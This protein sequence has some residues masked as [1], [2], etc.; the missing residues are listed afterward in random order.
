MDPASFA[1]SV[2]AVFKDAYLTAKFIRKTVNSIKGHR[3]EQ[4]KAV[5]RLTVQIYRLKN[6]SRLF[7]GVDGNKVDMQLLETV[8]N[9][10]LQTVHE[11]LEQ[12]QKVLADYTKLAA[13]LDEDY[14]TYSP[15]SPSFKFDP[16]KDTLLIDD[17]DD[18]LEGSCEPGGEKGDQVENSLD[19]K[20]KGWSFFGF[21][22]KNPSVKNIALWS[23]GLDPF[24]SLPPGVKWLFVK[25]KLEVTLRQFEDWNKQLEYLVGPL[26]DGFGFFKNPSLLSRLRP[27]GDPKLNIN[28]DIFQGHIELNS[29]SAE[30]Q[31]GAKDVQVADGMIPPSMSCIR[32]VADR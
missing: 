16:V 15:L 3:G 1:F 2:V 14:Q 20:G 19:V 6:L 17:D 21:A 23:K 28:I 4:E 32:L 12:L 5:T 31:T 29:A 25:G 7:R 10:Y 27:D 26:L 18:S 30:P 22:S 24:K 8:P 13:A 11:V 9:Q